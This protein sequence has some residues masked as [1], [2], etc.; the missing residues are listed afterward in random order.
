MGSNR[1]NATV[2]EHQSSLSLSLW[3]FSAPGYQRAATNLELHNC[4]PYFGFLSKQ[5]MI[6]GA[7]RL[8]FSL[9]LKP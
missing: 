1:P 6:K 2:L 8:L 4:M 3:E 9:C 5:R 7:F